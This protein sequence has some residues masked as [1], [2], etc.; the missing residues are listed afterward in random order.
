V[1][2]RASRDRGLERI[3][4]VTRWLVAGSIAGVV[5]AS[6]M[7][8]RAIPSH[9]HGASTSAGGGTGS[10]GGSGGASSSSTVP[11][12][13]GVTGSGSTDNGGGSIDSGSQSGTVAPLSPPVQSPLGGFGRGHVSSGAS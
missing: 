7:V 8:A 10:S 1:N 9:P 12:G 6:A 3:S 2:T 13:G 4:V 11:S 5:L